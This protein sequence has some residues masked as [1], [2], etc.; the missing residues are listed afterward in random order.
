MYTIIPSLSLFRFAW[1]IKAANMDIMCP[2]R[3]PHSLFAL[4]VYIAVFQRINNV[5]NILTVLFGQYVHI[6]FRCVEA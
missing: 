6:C 4:A 5:I 2:A 1:K 3:N